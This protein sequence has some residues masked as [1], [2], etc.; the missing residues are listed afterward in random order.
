MGNPMMD[1]FVRETRAIVTGTMAIVRFGSCGALNERAPCGSVIVPRG[2]YCIRR[3]L[4]YFCDQPVQPQTSQQPYLISGVFNADADMSE[5]LADAL[6]NVLAPLPD[7]GPIITGGLNAD[8]CSFYSAQGRQDPAFWDD[9][10]LLIKN[11]LVTHP[12]TD[13]LEMETSM[14]YHLAN[15]ARG[16]PI[17]ATGCMQAFFNRV[18][19]DAI[20]PETVQILEPAVGRACLD[21]LVDTKIEGEMDPQGTVWERL[22]AA[23][24]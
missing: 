10:E 15:C 17:R 19:N 12:D 11:A 24:S 8:G 23:S 18:T 9:N 20:R 13:S 5:R 7:V 2:G 16:Q 4:D 3:N 6:T 21:A 22:P 14:L 1:F